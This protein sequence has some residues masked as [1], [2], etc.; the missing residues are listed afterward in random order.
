MNRTRTDLA[1]DINLQSIS[2][3]T[4]HHLSGAPTWVFLTT[5]NAQITV[6][7]AYRLDKLQK[8]STTFTQ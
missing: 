4:T 2:S 6:L 1:E 3:H 8:H 5:I 7:Y